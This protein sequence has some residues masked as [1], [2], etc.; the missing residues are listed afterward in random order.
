MKTTLIDGRPSDLLRAISLGLSLAVSA[1][2]MS[3]SP[4]PTSAAPPSTSSA[5]PMSVAGGLS[6]SPKNGQTADQ[7]SADRYACYNWAVKESNWDPATQH[8]SASGLAKYRQ[9]MTACLEGRGYSV[10]PEA[11]PSPAAPAAA[12]S[13]GALTTVHTASGPAELRY[14]PFE[15]QIDGGYT[16]AVGTTDRNLS[17]G[18]TGGLG[19][20]WFPTSTLPLGL[21]IDGSYGQFNLKNRAVILDAPGFTSGYQSIYGGDADLQFD[22]AHPS[23]HYK[24]YLLGGVGWYRVQTQLRRVAYQSGVLCGWYYCELAYF[25]TVVAERN[26]TSDWEKSW[27]AGVG[28]ELAVAPSTSF[29]IEARYRHFLASPSNNNTS[30]TFVPVTLG[31]RF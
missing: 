28:W 6:V 21:R 29:F 30:T 8:G 14:R 22:L 25:P 27:N 7:Q 10:A 31:L 16:A 20:A 17:G 4:P 19:I 15:V 23:S 2:A 1:P 24:F 3:Q 9:A 5:A 11:V 26:T 12:A 18:A 13:A